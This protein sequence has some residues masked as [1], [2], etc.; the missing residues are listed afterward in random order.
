VPAGGDERRVLRARFIAALNPKFLAVDLLL[1]PGADGV[2]EAALR[3]SLGCGNPLAVAG[4]HP[5][6][7][8]LDLGSGGGLD[9]LL[10][11]RVVRKAGRIWV[12]VPMAFSARRVCW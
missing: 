5:G 8:V 4:L 11:T 1:Y 2:P 7:T 9:V 10:D 3:A 12:V 6:E